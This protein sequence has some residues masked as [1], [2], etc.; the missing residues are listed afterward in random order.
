MSP[1]AVCTTLAA[2][3]MG[4][5]PYGITVD[6]TYVYWTNSISGEV[7]KIKLD[8]TGQTTVATGQGAPLALTI[9]NGYLYWVSYSVDG[10]MRKTPLAGGA[11][12][13]IIDAPTARDVVVHGSTVFW[14]REPDDIQ[15]V[16]VDGLPEGGAAGLLSANQLT[17]GIAV[18]ATNVYWVNRQ[19]G[20]IKKCDHDLT[21]ETPLSIGNVPWDVAIDDTNIYW[22]ERGI[23]SAEGKVI[24]AN[25]ADGAGLVE[26]ATGL[27]RPEGIAVDATH[28]YWA[29]SGDGTI[30]KVPIAGGAPVIIATGQ[31]QP[32]N[33]AVDGTHVYW[34]DTVANVVV[35][36]PK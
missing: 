5:G 3:P 28:L 31:V 25:K 8:G 27:A 9:D 23:A 22:S 14:T 19:D 6:A 17:N 24:R 1:C 36:A 33:L 29:S 13:D 30:N 34:T 26:L 20:Y 11:L 16:P 12:I 21:N 35:K 32:E 2:L 7:M 4:S 18:D 15:S 10:V